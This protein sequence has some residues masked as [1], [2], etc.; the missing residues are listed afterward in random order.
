MP[1]LILCE[2]GPHEPPEPSTM[3]IGN[4]RTGEQLA[5]CDACLV[6]W[7]VTLIDQLVPPQ[8]REP[9]FRALLPAEAEPEPV[10]EPPKRGRRRPAAAEIEAAANE[11]APQGVAEEAAAASD[12]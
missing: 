2:M 8:N 1:Q 11:P 4:Q 5:L 6:G 10:A 3:L 9:V 7:A 12:G